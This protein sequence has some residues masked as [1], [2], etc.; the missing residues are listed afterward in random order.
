MKRLIVKLKDRKLVSRLEEYC[1]I[2]YV[3]K[4]IN[5]VGIEIRPDLISR[6][7]HDDNVISFRE[8]EEGN[9]Q[10]TASCV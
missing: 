3:S 4:F 7:N 1:D 2:I 9:Y 5:T 6:L 8:S 10:P